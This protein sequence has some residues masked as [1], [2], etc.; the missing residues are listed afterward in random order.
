MKTTPYIKAPSVPPPAQKMDVS[1]LRQKVQDHLANSRL[2]EAFKLLKKERIADNTLT[3]LE[4]RWSKLREEEM[5]GILSQGESILQRNQI[6][7]GLLEYLDRL[8][9]A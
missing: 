7:D 9:S 8:N 6:K 5:K 4:S 2:K 3:I 1:T